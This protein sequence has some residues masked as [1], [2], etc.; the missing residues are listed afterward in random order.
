ML[1]LFAGS[2]TYYYRRL[3][4]FRPDI[5]PDMYPCAIKKRRWS[6]EKIF[7]LGDRELLPLLA[8]TLPE[9]RDRAERIARIDAEACIREGQGLALGRIQEVM[10]LSLL[11]ALCEVATDQAF[12]QECRDI[13]FAYD[14]RFIPGEE[15]AWSIAK[16]V[17]SE[18]EGMNFPLGEQP[19][20]I[21]LKKTYLQRI[22]SRD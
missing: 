9:A 7:E 2:V 10:K 1:S 13:L 12:R 16:L 8:K 11:L 5:I 21:R 20:W 17:G 6:V 15:I 22:G 19:S 14:G 3:K 4:E 18:K